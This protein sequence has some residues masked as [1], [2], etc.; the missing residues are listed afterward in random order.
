M[1]GW[2][3][4]KDD[5]EWKKHVRTTI[6]L[7]RADRK[8]KIEAAKGAVV[9]G[10]KEAGVRS[11]SAGGTL[12]Q[13]TWWGLSGLGRGAVGLV[14]Q[15]FALIGRGLDALG[16]FL[17]PLVAGT[18]AY[19]GR[20][21]VRLASTVTLKFGWTLMKIGCVKSAAFLASPIMPKRPF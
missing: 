3:K 16:R 6:R 18:A 20:K 21:P 15:L 8:R 7:K 9:E 2:F 19:L 1:L 14:G 5:F 13:R 10:V 17:A 12:L 11:I 4:R